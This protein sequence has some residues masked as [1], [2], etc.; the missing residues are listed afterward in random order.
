MDIDTDP[1]CSRTTGPDMAL[2]SN[3]GL[4]V[5]TAPEATQDTPISMTLAVAYP[6]DTNMVS[7]PQEAD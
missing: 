6:L 2:G 1:R 3:S 5:T 7:W 4:G